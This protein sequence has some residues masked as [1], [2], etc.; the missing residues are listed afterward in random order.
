M[1]PD[2]EIHWKIVIVL[3]VL[4][5]SAILYCARLA[6]KNKK[7]SEKYEEIKTNQRALSERFT[8]KCSDI[9]R[10]EDMLLSIELLITTTLQSNN[11]ERL[12]TLYNSFHAIKR[13]LLNTEGVNENDRNS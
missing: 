3:F 11:S 6:H 7:L 4:F 8:V 5:I 9:K 10:Y 2:L 1:F 13:N 12:Q